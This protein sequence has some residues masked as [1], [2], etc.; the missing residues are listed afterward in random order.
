MNYPDFYKE[1][2]TIKLYDPLSDF[3]GA[4]EDGEIEINY[5]DCVKVAG[6][7]CPTVAGAYLM[8]QEGL[9]ALYPNEMPKRGD[10]KVQMRDGVEEA[11]T[12][13]TANII[14]YIVGAGEKGGFKGIQTKFNRANL[15]SFNTDISQEVKLTRSD[16]NQSV[17]IS[18]DPSSIKADERVMPLMGK[19]LKGL[20]SKEE[21]ILF[22]S[23]W[24]KRVE[25]I[26]LSKDVNKQITMNTSLI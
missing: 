24:Q 8:A 9:K 3:L 5:L 25:D 21:K 17:S 12:G 18:Y 14:A 1:V 16:T 6:H 26:L 20:A 13:V 10:I 22:N 11:V 2:P 7:S 15:L 4:L 23:L 19:N